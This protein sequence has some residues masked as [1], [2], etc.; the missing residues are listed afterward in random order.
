MT[1]HRNNP[2]AGK[3]FSLILSLICIFMVKMNFEANMNRG[4]EILLNG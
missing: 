2:H 1:K 3:V 4:I